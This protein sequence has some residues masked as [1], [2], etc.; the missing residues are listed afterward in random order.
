MDGDP[1]ALPH[2][3]RPAYALR[4]RRSGLLA[5]FDDAGPVVDELL[6]GLA[7]PAAP[8]TT[9]AA[10]ALGVRLAQ[11]D[12]DLD[13]LTRSL[14]R[15]RQLVLEQLHDAGLAADLAAARTVHALLDR[16]A[17]ASTAA[18]LREREAQVLSMVAH[19]VSNPLMS[20]CL[21]AGF[22]EE[23]LGPEHRRSTDTLQRAAQQL[24]QLVR[25]VQDVADILAGPRT[26]APLL[27]D[28][29]DVVGEVVGQLEPLA[30][31]RGVKLAATPPAGPAPLHGE[32][33]RLVQA[34][35]CL[36]RAALK[37]SRAD[38]TVTIDA[39]LDGPE[40]RLAVRD[41][42]P[43]MSDAA[44]ARAF[45]PG[46]PTAAPGRK[47]LNAE[48]FIARSVVE[49]HGGRIWLERAPQ[50]PGLRVTLALPLAEPPPEPDV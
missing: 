47:K 16:L 44:R 30:R 20:I 10:A 11:G 9:A 43:G 37:V 45:E 17:E 31:A 36:V 2:S 28:L 8:P 12:D 21:I 15:L 49:A 13:V 14:A 22:F 29:G 4:D 24:R 38:Q 23:R 50:G 46:L 35:G 26:I 42:G 25:D 1:L 19:D 7:D 5:A 39:E 33:E 6:A 27:V 48:L 40:V 41:H 3:T 34:L 18:F 32:R